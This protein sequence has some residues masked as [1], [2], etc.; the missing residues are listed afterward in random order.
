MLIENPGGISPSEDVSKK[1][2]NESVSLRESLG[3]LGKGLNETRN[4]ILDTHPMHNRFKL[5]TADEVLLEGGKIRIGSELPFVVFDIIRSG[6][7]KLEYCDPRVDGLEK[8][9]TLEWRQETQGQNPTLHVGY[10]ELVTFYDHILNVGRPKK[11]I[12]FYGDTIIGPDNVDMP[13]VLKSILE[14][15]RML[16]DVSNAM[17]EHNNWL[18][19]YSIMYDDFLYHA[20]GYALQALR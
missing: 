16:R 18:K 8:P 17:N 13:N 7:T 6:E 12:K 3:I 10:R 9:Y 11:S 2:V 19:E 5:I 4:L 1:I 15:H 14:S 20:D